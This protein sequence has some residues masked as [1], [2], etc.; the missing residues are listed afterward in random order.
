CTQPGRRTPAD[1]LFAERRDRSETRRECEPPNPTQS[2]RQSDAART[3]P[4]AGRSQTDA[5]G[6]RQ[7]R[8]PVGTIAVVSAR[9]FR[10]RPLTGLETYVA[11]LV[12]NAVTR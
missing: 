8:G 4:H 12:C 10:P 9:A 1:R 2:P 7:G 6:F 5:S 11:R 3:A